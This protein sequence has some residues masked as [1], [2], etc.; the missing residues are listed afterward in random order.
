MP[1]TSATKLLLDSGEF[2]EVMDR[3]MAAAGAASPIPGDSAAPIYAAPT[4]WSCN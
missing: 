1:Y 3:C 4:G 2:E